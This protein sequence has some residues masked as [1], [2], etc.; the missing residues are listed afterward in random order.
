MEAKTTPLKKTSYRIQR[1]YAY[2]LATIISLAVP[3]ITINGNHLFLLSF[4]KKQLHLMGIAFDMQEL[5]HKTYLEDKILILEIDN[6]PANTLS[7]AIKRQ[8]GKIINEIESN[9][10]LNFP[11]YFS[12]SLIP[13]SLVIRPFLISSFT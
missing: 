8:F 6:P 3:F 1:Y 9:S 5:I 7:K 2:I 13:S 11:S 4:D 10:K 12:T